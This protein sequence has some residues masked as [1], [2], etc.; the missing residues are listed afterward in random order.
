MKKC[1]A[2][3]FLRVSD[4]GEF[5]PNFAGTSLMLAL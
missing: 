2:Q 4:G 5:C 3:T 1:T